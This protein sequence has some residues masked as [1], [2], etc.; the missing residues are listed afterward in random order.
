MVDK[1]VEESTEI[2]I[3]MIVMTEAGTGVERGHFGRNRTRKYKQ[4]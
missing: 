4:Q 3:E 2:A 1:T